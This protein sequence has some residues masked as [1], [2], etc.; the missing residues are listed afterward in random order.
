MEQRF[1]FEGAEVR[2]LVEESRA[3]AER[4]M[5][6]AQRC[7]A[8]GVSPESADPDWEAVE[9]HPDTGAPP[10]L[11]LRNDRGVYLS[12]NAADRPEGSVAAARGYRAEVQV[13]DE[14]FCE[15]I[16]AGQLDLLEPDDTLVVTLTEHK[17]KLSLLRG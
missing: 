11:W 6:F 8:A 5:T 10:G 1:E 2:A 12:S 15:F 4:R 7:L 17:V 3:A 13:G 14:E 9:A 16:D